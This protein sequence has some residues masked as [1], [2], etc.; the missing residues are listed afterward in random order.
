MIRFF[1]K[2][3]KVIF[4]VIVLIILPTFGVSYVMLDVIGG[5]PGGA[6]RPVGKLFGDEVTSAEFAVARERLLAY[7]RPFG[8]AKAPPR[9]IWDHLT[10]LR[11]AERAGI[12][13][14]PAE[15][16]DAVENAFREIIAGRR[17][18]TRVASLPDNVRESPFFEYQ[19]RQL[20]EEERQKAEA[21]PFNQK[22]YNDFL[23]GDPDTPNDDVRASDFEA[24]LLE[25]VK[26]QKLRLVAA[27]AAK[28]SPE[29][30]YEQYQKENH[31][32]RM[33]YVAL[34]P[35]GFKVDPAKVTDEDLKKHYEENKE[36]FR[37]PTMVELEAA[38]ARFADIEKTVPE[39][40]EED[41][42]ARYEAKKETFRIPPPPGPPT[43]AGADAKYRSFEEVKEELAR[44]WK[45]EKLE[46]P[47]KRNASDARE[48]AAKALADAVAAA[49][50]DPAKLDAFDL[51]AAVEA[52]GLAYARYPA[53]DLAKLMDLEEAVRYFQI[54]ADARGLEPRTALSEVRKNP[55][56]F[57]FVRVR[58]RKETYLPE[59]EA[60]KDKV[61]ESYVNVSEEDLVHH[62][63]THN[64]DYREPEK[65][66]L[67]WAFAPYD[68]FLAK[69]P[70]EVTDEAKRK[71]EARR[72]AEAALEK[73]RTRY[74]EDRKRPEVLDKVDLE[75]HALAEG[76][77]FGKTEGPIPRAGAESGTGTG[78]GTDGKLPEVLSW[79]EVAIRLEDKEDKP[80]DLSPALEDEKKTGLAVYRVVAEVEAKV[81][82]LAEIK[83]RVRA[84]VLTDRAWK[85]AMD[86]AREAGKD[87]GAKKTTIEK[88]A[89]KH[90]LEIKVTPYFRS[91]VEDVDGIGPFSRTLATRAL[92]LEK[93]C[94]AA[95]PASDA[96]KKVAYLYQLAAKEPADPAGFAEKREALE[97]QWR[98]GMSPFARTAHAEE[99]DRFAVE[100][101]LRARGIEEDEL[102][103]AYELRSG[104]DGL[105][106]VEA[107]H[108]VVRADADTMKEGLFEK[109]KKEA[110]KALAQI[111]AARNPG[112]EL[113]KLAKKL[114]EDEGSARKEGGGDL[115]FFPRGR[116]RPLFGDEFDAVAFA[117]KDGEISEPVRS[118]LGY[119]I[120]QTVERRGEGEGLEVHARH[121]LFKADPRLRGE[122]DEAV[123]KAAM[124]K[125]K[126]KVLKADERLKAGEEFEAVA[127]DVSE[128]ASAT[129]KRT[130]ALLSPFEAAALDA[131]AHE[132]S[133]YAAPAG[134]SAPAG[135]YLLLPQTYRPEDA[136]P[137]HGKQEP[138]SAIVRCIFKRAGEEKA[139]ERI[140]TELAD[141][142]A[143]IRAEGADEGEWL[144]FVDAFEEAAAKESDAE[145]GRRGGNVGVIA[146]DAALIRFGD[147]FRREIERLG[148]GGTSGIVEGK[149]AFYIIRAFGPVKKTFAEVRIG[150]AKELIEGAEL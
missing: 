53:T 116:Q 24:T 25:V 55:T 41:L 56:G 133:S 150:V 31:R 123:L 78:T 130:Y 134:A 14:T 124:A 112:E 110:E 125:A 40:S 86:A 58:D 100:V 82:D 75:A 38:T 6:D 102:R 105:A 139:L 89:E 57:L 128:D 60:V 3:E 144:A 91:D 114:S 54:H 59:L 26:I 28:P 97:E 118:E 79:P 104:K 95:G 136:G 137:S 44:D 8:G 11:E 146:E 10:F 67:E 119:H 42:K 96:E 15:L 37:V 72:L 131:P 117:Q 80:F 122:V 46:D 120:L 115:G 92:G 4:W 43:E 76:L 103:E 74:D 108:L 148:P 109:A 70:P 142:R 61:R 35:E 90:G 19:L 32:R 21:V 135:T 20:Y 107:A 48:A 98:L 121:M 106:G 145:S 85:R 2:Y 30:L 81:P 77:D 149:D 111:R 132:V 69:V 51:K 126:E 5:R 33:R 87:L 88:L 7:K 62:F 63:N 17:V 129:R 1:R 49:A 50:G 99:Q 9:E 18:W 83:E 23:K 16:R 65:V 141:R 84:D 47:A 143:E 68:R 64:P 36:R 45:R 52:Q 147:G 12:A 22:Q 94:D 29:K 101:R 66:A 13:V 140:R 93:V 127:A 113:K 27:L 73:L 138:R 34:T 39:P 71:A